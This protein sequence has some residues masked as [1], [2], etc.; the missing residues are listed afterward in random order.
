MGLKAKLCHQIITSV[1]RLSAHEGMSLARRAGLTTEDFK[2]VVHAGTAWSKAVD[3]W[4]E[5]ELP[6]HHAEMLFKDLRLAIEMANEMD[7]ALP[8]S[9]LAQ[10]WMQTAKAPR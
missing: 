6:A 7:V 8:F 2:S 4:S 5:K 9:A 1:N 10:Q 3:F